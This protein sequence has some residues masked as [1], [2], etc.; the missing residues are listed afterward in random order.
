MAVKKEI[1]GPLPGI[2]QPHRPG[3]IQWKMNLPDDKGQPI[4]VPVS[5][6]TQFDP[7]QFFLK[8]E[9][10]AHQA[11]L[12]LLWVFSRKQSEPMNV[13]VPEARKLCEIISF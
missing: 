3:E 12:K 5:L 7:N 6:E 9:E 13:V 10:H 2:G 8:K 11:E 1:T 4:E